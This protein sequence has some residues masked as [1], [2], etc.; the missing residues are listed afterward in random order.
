M[1]R[2]GRVAQALLALVFVVL[3]VSEIGLAVNGLFLGSILALGA[4]GITLVFGVILI[5]F[6]LFL[7]RGVV[8]SIQGWLGKARPGR[9]GAIGAGRR[10]RT[11]TE[12]ARHNG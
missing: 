8:P 3:A 9:G 5:L 1:Q 12:R 10:R 4:V 7:P 11:R 6:I 2:I